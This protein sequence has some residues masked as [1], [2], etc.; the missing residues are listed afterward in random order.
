V[1]QFF[2]YICSP[3]RNEQF[4]ARFYKVS[5]GVRT[6]NKPQIDVN[7]KF[8]A[9][10]HLS[11]FACIKCSV[12]NSA[13]LSQINVELTDQK[14]GA[15]GSGIHVIEEANLAMGALSFE[16]RTVTYDCSIIK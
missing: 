2:P 12:V 3:S 13:R 8:V 14:T 1:N 5:R 6:L 16:D 15:N 9:G 10:I 4:F 7:S 11:V